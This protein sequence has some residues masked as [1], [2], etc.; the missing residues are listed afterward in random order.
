MEHKKVNFLHSVRL[1]MLL[2]MAFFA[3]VT[4]GFA[5]ALFISSTKEEI[6]SVTRGYMRDLSRAYGVMLDNELDTDGDD[7]LSGEHL[8]SILAGVQVEGVES[9]YIYVVSGDGTMLYHPTADKIGKPVENKVVIPIEDE[10]FQAVYYFLC[11]EKD[12]EKF[13]ALIARLQEKNFRTEP[14]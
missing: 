12:R 1:K 11:L 10:D 5:C 2:A 7:A 14:F 6:G 4:G 13:R 8:A 3:F 9:S